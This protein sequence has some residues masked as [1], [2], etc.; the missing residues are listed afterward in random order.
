[1]LIGLFSVFNVAG[2][3]NRLPNWNETIYRW[4]SSR[5]FSYLSLFDGQPQRI[6]RN[7]ILKPD[8]I[9]SYDYI[10]YR[11]QLNWFLGIEAVSDTVQVDF[12]K[13]SYKNDTLKLTIRDSMSTYLIKNNTLVS[14][15]FRKLKLH[16]QMPFRIGFGLNYGSDLFDLDLTLHIDMFP[17]KGQNI[18]LGF[19]GGMFIGNFTLGT[20]LGYQY[21]FLIGQL[22]FNYRSYPMPVPMPEPIYSFTINPK[23][24][25]ELGGLYIK[26]GPD[27]CLNK[28]PFPEEWHLKVLNVPV[29]VEIGY[30]IKLNNEIFKY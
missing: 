2:Q 26:A 7:L 20:S 11:P 27:I 25:I 5:I 21:K 1:M 16:Y 22:A 9:F 17:I 15:E 30:F 28:D 23:I 24:G 29:K 8:N 18:I 6:E 4:H 3:L 12:G 10:I 19:T 14:T 13:Y